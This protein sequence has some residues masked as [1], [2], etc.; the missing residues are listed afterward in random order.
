MKF[1]LLFLQADKT[2]VTQNTI[3]KKIISNII[4]NIF[5]IIYFEFS[6]SS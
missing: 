1:L 6:A 4:F 2:K 3:G 5:K